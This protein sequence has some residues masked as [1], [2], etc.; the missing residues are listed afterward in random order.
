MTEVKMKSLRDAYGQALA[1]LGAENENIVVLDADL[2]GSTRTSIFAARFPERFFN[3][4]VAE[5]DMVSTAAGLAAAGKIPFA[6]TFAVFASGRAWDQV[7]QSVCMGKMNVKIVA[8]HGGITVGED[9]PTHQALE[10]I[11]LMRVMPNITVIVPA[12]AHETAAA[13]R[14]A[15]Q[16]SGPFYI[17]T[18]RDK[19]PVLLREDVEFT[20][21]KAARLR[22]GTDVAIIACGIMVS[23]AL[24]AAEV[25]SNEGVSAAVVNMSSI[26]PIDVEMIVSMARETGAIVTAEEHSIIGGL[27]SAVAEEV[28]ETEPVP[29]IR[30]GMRAAVGS[31]GAPEELLNLF[32]MNTEAVVE[33]ARKAIGMKKEPA[34]TQA[35]TVMTG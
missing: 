29:V 9:G 22:E 13:V 1:D 21:G 24:E 11:A 27:G 31:S 35:K 25:L 26:K 19:F 30:V 15:A 32:G 28:S 20:P 17:R 18:A 10:D 5:Q 23:K 16:L 12:D 4:G 3:M 6:S 34:A 2:S 33:A 8:S 14:R 7:R